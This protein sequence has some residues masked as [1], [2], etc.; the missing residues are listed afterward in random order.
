MPVLF[1]PLNNGHLPVLE[2]KVRLFRPLSVNGG[3]ADQVVYC[4]RE[5]V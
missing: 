2:T 3:G 5:V 4:N 1:S